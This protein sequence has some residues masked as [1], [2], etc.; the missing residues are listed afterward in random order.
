MTVPVCGTDTPSQTDAAAAVYDGA[1]YAASLPTPM[2]D[3]ADEWDRWSDQQSQT[4]IGAKEDSVNQDLFD[5]WTGWRA[6]TQVAADHFH[7]ALTTISR[8]ERGIRANYEFAAHYR[9]C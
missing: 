9:N 4:R 8:T 6:R 7:L 3:I 2:R 1:A 5:R